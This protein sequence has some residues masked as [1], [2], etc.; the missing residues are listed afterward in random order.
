MKIDASP[1]PL[2]VRVLERTDRHAATRVGVDGKKHVDAGATAAS[3]WD[4]A[5]LDFTIATGGAVLTG[6]AT[7]D[8]LSPNLFAADWP[9]TAVAVVLGAAS[10]GLILDGLKN[11]LEAGAWAAVAGAQRLFSRPG[12]TL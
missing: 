4:A 6:A 1:D 9:A 7:L 2:L 11:T 8:Y 5:K 3:N 12:A 10:A